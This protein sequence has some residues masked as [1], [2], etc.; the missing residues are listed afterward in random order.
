[1]SETLVLLNGVTSSTT[2]AAVQVPVV[3]REVALAAVV[4]GPGGFGSVVIQGSF[5]NSLWF[6]LPGLSLGDP[7]FVT[8]AS[9]IRWLRAVYSDDG[10]TGA[11]TV[12]ALQSDEDG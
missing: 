1:V 5:D 4:S 2:G 6:A 12:Q 8:F 7:G 9:P 11:V 10:A 3:G